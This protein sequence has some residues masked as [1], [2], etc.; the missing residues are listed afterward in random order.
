MLNNIPVH[1]VSEMPCTAYPFYSLACA[2]SKCQFLSPLHFVENSDTNPYLI[3]GVTL[4]NLLR[5]P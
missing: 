3:H 4:M 1:G 2:R 5:I